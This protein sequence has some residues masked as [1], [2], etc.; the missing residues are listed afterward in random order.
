VEEVLQE[1]RV[2]PL[3]SIGEAHRNQQVHDFIVRLVTDPRFSQTVD[4]I[5]VE[6]GTARHQDIID[7]YSLVS[8]CRFQS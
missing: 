7:R 4:D 5:V 8:R 1:F 6:F 2:C 3:V